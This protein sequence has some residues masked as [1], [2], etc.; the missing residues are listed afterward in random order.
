MHPKL[1]EGF[2]E[3]VKIPF[4]FFDQE[5]LSKSEFERLNELTKKN[6]LL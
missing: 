5:Q 2:K 3:I 1:E 4:V 6:T